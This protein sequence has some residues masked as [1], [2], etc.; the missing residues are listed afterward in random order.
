MDALSLAA[1]SHGRPGQTFE[2]D[3]GVLRAG[4]YGPDDAT[5]WVARRG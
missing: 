4:R 5:C 3:A 2:L 1:T